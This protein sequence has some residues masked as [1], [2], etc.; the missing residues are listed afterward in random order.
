MVTK[1]DWGSRGGRDDIRFP[2]CLKGMFIYMLMHMPLVFGVL[3]VYCEGLVFTV[4]AVH[5]HINNKRNCTMEDQE[6]HVGGDHNSG[7]DALA[8]VALI[9]IAVAAAVFWISQH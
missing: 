6:T 8:A 5:S 4:S 9:L 3:L 7:L 2:L 1:P